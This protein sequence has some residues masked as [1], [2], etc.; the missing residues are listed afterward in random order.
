MYPVPVGDTSGVL[1]FAIADALIDLLIKKDIVDR[2]EINAMFKTLEIRLAKSGDLM[3][4]RG[5]D[6]IADTVFRKK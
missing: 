1:G 2:T 4:K 5:A 6:F 3:S